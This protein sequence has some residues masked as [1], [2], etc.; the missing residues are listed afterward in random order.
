MKMIGEKKV[1]IK[2]TLETNSNQWKT[3]E[4]LLKHFGENYFND[5]SVFKITE[6]KIKEDEKNEK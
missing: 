1:K 4:E 3:E 2:L 5:S 6:V